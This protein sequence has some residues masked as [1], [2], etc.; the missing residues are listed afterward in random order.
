MLFFCFYFFMTT[1]K[2]SLPFYYIVF[3]SYSELAPL[4][5]HFSI[6]WLIRCV[7][8]ALTHIPCTI[9]FALQLH[10]FSYEHTYIHHNLLLCHNSKNN[11][12]CK[13]IP[14]FIPYY[15]QTIQ[16]DYM[17]FFIFHH[18]LLEMHCQRRSKKY[19]IHTKQP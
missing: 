19:Y 9:N 14:L 2:Y 17:F 8:S 7:V 10:R 16:I 3:N 13:I 4:T 5:W 1:F 15:R 11:T 12:F 18:I 6:P